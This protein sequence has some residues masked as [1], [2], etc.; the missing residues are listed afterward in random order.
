MDAESELRRM[1]ANHLDRY[2]FLHRRQP[3]VADGVQPRVSAASCATKRSADDDDVQAAVAAANENTNAIT[4]AN[5]NAKAN[6]NAN[7]N[8]NAD[9]NASANARAN[10]TAND[11]A[12]PASASSSVS[13]VSSVSLVSSVVAAQN[14]GSLASSAR[15]ATVTS[16]SR[17]LSRPLRPS[18]EQRGRDE[19]R[20]R[21]AEAQPMLCDLIQPSTPS[22]LVGN[23]RNVQAIDRLMKACA[24]NTCAQR[25]LVVVGPPGCGK[26]CA[27][28]LL[29]KRAGFD[30]TRMDMSSPLTARTMTSVVEKRPIG[31]NGRRPVLALLDGLELLDGVGETA[32]RLVMTNGMRPFLKWT[33]DRLARQRRRRANEKTAA[34]KQSPSLEE[35][36]PAPLRRLN[37]LV[38]IADSLPAFFHSS[39]FNQ[40]RAL[41]NVV[42]FWPLK[43]DE[44][45]SIYRQTVARVGTHRSMSTGQKKTLHD[46]IGRCEGD[47][48]YML[49]HLEVA[50]LTTH[51][52]A[53]ESLL[54]KSEAR[55]SRGGVMQTMR[56]AFF[57]V[58]DMQ[59][60]TIR[61]RAVEARRVPRGEA[62]RLLQ[63]Y[64]RR[65]RAMLVSVHANYLSLAIASPNSQCRRLDSLSLLADSLSEADIV[66][67]HIGR[68]QDYALS[69]FAAYAGFV[70]L[71][72][73]LR[74]HRT[75]AEATTTTI[76]PAHSA[77]SASFSLDWTREQ[78]RLRVSVS[79]RLA[80]NMM[81][82][83]TGAGSASLRGGKRNRKRR[84]PARGD[85]DGSRDEERRGET[86]KQRKVLSAASSAARKDTRGGSTLARGK[87]A[88]FTISELSSKEK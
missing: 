34:R 12:R 46:F 84:A 88:F 3:L 24:Q 70:R 23:K 86:A 7:A 69:H 47:A 50:G 79:D 60:L 17:A 10:A 73:S 62:D 75:C 20:R 19:Q 45:T 2:S 14:S 64:A 82:S 15:A 57:P 30:V 8:M 77:L 74:S 18:R 6:V 51:G 35:T 11:P 59:G 39:A 85:G 61:G 5:A 48:R 37:P 68:S 41:C 58:K 52:A 1:S 72:R 67:S 49:N 44:M 38:C 83:V 53:S 32:Q 78:R 21:R 42:H 43:R 87:T 4:N 28:R 56:D 26:S 25:V 40:Q 13:S 71:V 9:V 33:R 80:G 36:S 22:Q 29:S 16:C 65:P 55:A 66:C 54:K 31:I 27:V 63:M 76:Q 81:T